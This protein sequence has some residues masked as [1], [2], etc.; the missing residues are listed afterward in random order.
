MRTP[1]GAELMD[2]WERA[3]PLAPEGRA[4]ALL[5]AV[6]PGAAWEDLAALPL[7]RRDALLLALRTAVCGPRLEGTATC[8]AC[9]ER[10]EFTLVEDDLL[11][12]A[13][14]DAPTGSIHEG[15]FDVT[16]RL[17]DSTDP[18][19]LRRAPDAETARRLLLERCVIEAR[20]GADT[21][22]PA[23]LPE[24]VVRAVAAEMGRLDPQAELRLALTC[25]ACTHTWEIVFDVA[26]FFWAELDAWARRTLHE[27][28]LLATAY[29]WAERD[30]LALSPWRRQAYLNM[31]G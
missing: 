1:S 21:V 7:G 15:G 28:H 26:G 9:S 19:P 31:I 6:L 22:S 13:P 18:Q 8:L 27:V 10:V 14:G 23:D 24:P 5:V 20:H 11:V 25:P 17:P 2:V 3:A 12:P 4:L 30:I 16:F 29:G